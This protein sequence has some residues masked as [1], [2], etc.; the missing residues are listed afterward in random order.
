M[1]R[2]HCG[3]CINIL[4]KSICSVSVE[5]RSCPCGEPLQSRDD[6]IATYSIYEDQRQI[7]KDASEDLVTSDILGTKEGVEALI[8]FLRATNTFKKHQPPHPKY[9]QHN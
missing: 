6:I 5:D 8:T 7:F 9:L 2:D 1:W 4:A 3:V